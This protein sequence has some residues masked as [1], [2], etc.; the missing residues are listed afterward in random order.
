[1]KCEHVGMDSDGNC[2][3]CGLKIAAAITKPGIFRGYTD[4]NE[5]ISDAQSEENY[6]CALTLYN[7]EV[8]S[9]TLNKGR[10]ALEIRGAA[11]EYCTISGADVTIS[12]DMDA[13]VTFTDGRLSITGGTFTNYVRLKSSEARISGGRFADIDMTKNSK[14]SVLAGYLGEGRAFADKDSGEIVNG[15]VTGLKNVTVVPHAHDCRWNTETHEK[16]C[17]CGYVEATDSDAPVISGIENGKTYYSAAEFSVADAND[18]TVTVD[19]EEVQLTLGSYILMPDNKQHTVI[20]TDV[21]GNTTSVTVTVNMLYKVTLSSGAGYTLSGDPLVG[22][23]Q[24]YTFTLEI[25]KGYSKT[26]NFMVD[27]NGAPMHSDSGSYTVSP[28]TSDIVVTVFGVADITPP[29]AEITISTNKF[30][31]FMNTITFGLFFKK[32]QTVTVT[33]SDNGSGLSKAEYLLSETAF[34]DIGAITGDWTELTLADGSANFD[35][36]P[37][38]KAFVYLRVTDAS[39]NVSVINSDGVVVYT[40]AEAITEAI[41]FTKLDGADVSFR[42]SLNGNTVAALYNGDALLD[43]ADYTVSDDGTIILKKQ[44]PF[45]SCSR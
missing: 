40:D 13:W 3:Y 18:F 32:T 11:V 19:G 44:L 33:A 38:R 16:S 34:A 43:S 35:I 12:G 25:A 42:V 17:V 26:E 4:I 6:G 15:Y 2:P 36:E 9:L 37:D 29:A 45:R 28:V 14:I 27:V 7:G 41:S 21:A 22:H 30:N 10:L 39:G 23:G 8:K 31:S 1:M 5:A 24:E 20:A